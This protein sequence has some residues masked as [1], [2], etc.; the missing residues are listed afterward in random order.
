MVF[1]VEGEPPPQ[2]LKTAW[3]CEQWNSLPEEGGVYD[4][5]ARLISRMTACRNI[6]NTVSR[7]GNMHGEQIHNLSNRERDLLY[8][9][10]NMGLMYTAEKDEPQWVKDLRK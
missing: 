4:Q 10:R 5:D 8:D 7:V 9:L 6:Y 2:E 3:L 1:C